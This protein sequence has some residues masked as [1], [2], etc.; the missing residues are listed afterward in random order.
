MTF[1]HFGYIAVAVKDLSDSWKLA[2]FPQLLLL[3]RLSFWNKC[4]RLLNVVG[5][6][7]PLW[8]AIRRELA[9]VVLHGIR[10]TGLG[11]K[12]IYLR[13][14]PKAELALGIGKVVVQNGHAGKMA[15][16]LP[17]VLLRRKPQSVGLL[18]LPLMAGLGWGMCFCFCK[19]T[20]LLPRELLTPG[21][22]EKVV[23]VMWGASRERKGFRFTLISI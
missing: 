2:Q 11:K 19:E 16:V 20:Q 7:T 5:T 14:G 3:K 10:M 12:Y 22:A 4:W 9:T 17:P 1:P 18:S 23:I 8:G 15:V 6:S 21:S 13:R